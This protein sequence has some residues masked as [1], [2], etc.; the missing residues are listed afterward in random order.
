[1]TNSRRNRPEASVAKRLTRITWKRAFQFPIL[2]MHWATRASAMECAEILLRHGVSVDA[3][4]AAPRT[5]LQM[6]ADRDQI[7]MIR[8]LAWSGAKR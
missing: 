6:A 2:P 8:L 1:M 5:F 3:L 4:N 7:E